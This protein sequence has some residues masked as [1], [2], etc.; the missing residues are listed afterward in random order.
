LANGDIVS[1]S[2]DKTIRLWSANGQEKAVLEED[3]YSKN[4]E[5]IFAWVHQHGFDANDIYQHPQ[6]ASRAQRITQ[7]EKTLIIYDESTGET[8]AQFI[9]DNLITTLAV[10]DDDTLVMGDSVGRVIF[11]RVNRV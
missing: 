10:F 6:I 2:S 1:W 8:R 11:L 7:D 9:A 3:Y 5:K 4:R